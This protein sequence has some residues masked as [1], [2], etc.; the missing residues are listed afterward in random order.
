MDVAVEFNSL[1]KTYNMAGWR[2]GMAAGNKELIRWLAL[3]KTMTDSSSFIPLFSAG[4]TAMSGDQ[5]WLQERNRIYQIRRDLVVDCMQEIGFRTQVP[6]AGLYVWAKIPG[7]NIDSFAFCENILENSGVSVTPGA[8]F[9][10][11]GEGYLRVSLCTSEEKISD[12]L[13]RIKAFLS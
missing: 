9:G 12:A 3:Y 10:E 13:D 1:S 7:L 8:V 2:L 11:F 4:A 6:K 5:T